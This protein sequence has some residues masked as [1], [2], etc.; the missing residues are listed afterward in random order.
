MTLIY[1]R[2]LADNVP[3]HVMGYHSYEAITDMSR[4]IVRTDEDTENTPVFGLE[5]ECTK[6]DEYIESDELSQLFDMFPFFQAE[7]DSSIPGSGSMEVI[8]QPM[9]INAYKEAGF[10]AFMNKLQEMGF[11]AYSVTNHDNGCGCG[12]HIHINKGNNWE[13]V[14]ALMAMFIDQNKEIVQIICKRPFTS[15]ACNNLAPLNNSTKRYSLDYVQGYMQSNRNIHSNVI[16]LQHSASIEFRLPVGTLDYEVKMAH[17]EFLNNLYKCCEDVIN[18]NARID[19]LT[20]NKVCQSGEF[21]PKLMDELCISCSKKL[22]ILDKMIKS[23]ID[24]FNI[25]KCKVIK[26][27]SDLQLALATTNDTSIPSGSINN[28]NTHFTNITCADTI[29]DQM[30]Y[31]RNIV[32]TRVISRGLETYADSHNN[33]I[34]KYYKKLKEVCNGITLPQIY[35]DMKGE[36]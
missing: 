9:T 34:A 18:G 14:V 22:M 15:Y 23:K 5:I 30:C 24:T 3:H 28:I 36:K 31:V 17:I 7:S 29:D 12:G 25:D 16:N 8:T 11:K 19:R 32:T 1:E 26:A 4:Y 10:E 33:N 27:L 35:E 21:L 6:Y 2:K 20:I 13:R